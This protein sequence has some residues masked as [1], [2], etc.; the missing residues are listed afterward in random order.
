VY[1][2]LAAILVIVALAIPR[3]RPAGV[4][5]SVIL[6]ALLAWGVTQRLRGGSPELERGRPA[7]P[8]AQLQAVPIDLIDAQELRLTGGG[9]PFEL[10][11]RIVNRA[12]DAQLKSVT[13]QLTRRDCYEGALAP[14]GCVVLW[15]DRHWIPVSV[16]PGEARDFAVSIWARGAAARPRG[17]VQDSFEV[18]A[19]QGEGVERAER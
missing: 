3:L 19:A 2:I 9:A 6:G 13:I 16:P 18:Q 11:G 1:W 10:R 5:G 12:T 15:Q 14:G 17:T 7:S 8:A 4:V